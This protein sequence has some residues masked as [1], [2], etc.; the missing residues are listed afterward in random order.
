MSK[1]L[2]VLFDEGEFEEIKGVAA[3]HQMTVAD[4]VR[5]A[6]REARQAEPRFSDTRK[7]TAVREATRFEYPVADIDQ[8]L[9]ETESGYQE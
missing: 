7:L 6:L 4:W 9:S 5:G 3:R 2:Q 8:M 1:R